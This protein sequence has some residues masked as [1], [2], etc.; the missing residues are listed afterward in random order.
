M[1]FVNLTLVYSSDVFADKEH[2]APKLSFVNV[3]VLNKVLRS[4]IFV[5]ADKQLRVV[6]LVLDFKPLSNTF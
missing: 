5:S 3:P 2:V 4:K 1:D 6:H